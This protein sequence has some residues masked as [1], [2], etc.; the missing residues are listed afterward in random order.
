MKSKT[1]FRA[2]LL[3]VFILTF[4]LLTVL[5]IAAGTLTERLYD[6][7]DLLSSSERSE[8]RQRLN[9]V[10]EKYKIN[11][12]IVTT[13]D[14]DGKTPEAYADDFY[15]SHFGINTDGILLL[16]YKSAYDRYVHISTSGICISKFTDMD[17]ELILD[18]MQPYCENDDDAGSFFAFI[19]SVQNEFSYK[20][21]WI[22]IGLVIGLIVAGSVTGSMKNKLTSVKPQAYAGNYVRDNSL[23]ITESHD[24]F[25]YKN[26]SRVKIERTSSSSGGSS[27][28]TSSSGGSHGG[29]GRHM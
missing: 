1:V 27:T 13:S 18:N 28:H 10:S 11:V 19:D 29:G 12:I 3:L 8:L 14:L 23:N 7:A 21:I 16:R 25:L 22:F 20:K 9:E 17:I 5:P 6:Q 24:T 4:C 15:D 2:S 26:L